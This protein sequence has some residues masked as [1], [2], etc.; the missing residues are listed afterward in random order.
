MKIRILIPV[1][2]LFL[3]TFTVLEAQTKTEVNSKQ[4]SVLLQKDSKLIVLDVRTPEEFKEGHIKGAINIDI[5][6]EDAFSKIDKLNK[7]A[8]YLVYCRTNHRSGLA[9]DHML[10]NGFSNV[11]QMMDG[12]PGW[13]ANKLAIQK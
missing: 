5:R 13:A 2:L 1:L 6:Q 4:A 11:Y 12:F 8:K 10:Q 7:N 9:V 3:S